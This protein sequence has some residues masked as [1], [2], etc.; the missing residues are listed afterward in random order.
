MV[1]GSGCGSV[2]VG[3]SGAGGVSLDRVALA[4][5]DDFFGVVGRPLL[6][7]AVRSILVIVLKVVIE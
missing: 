6:E 7:A 4:D 1:G 5:R 2:L 3:E